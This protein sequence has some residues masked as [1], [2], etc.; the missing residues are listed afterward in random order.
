MP[1]ETFVDNV[2]RR[3]FDNFAEYAALFGEQQAVIAELDVP[4]IKSARQLPAALRARL[5]TQAARSEAA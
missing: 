4:R 3:R 1:A 2:T 5:P